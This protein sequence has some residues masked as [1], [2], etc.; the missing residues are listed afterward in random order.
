MPYLQRFW[1]YLKGLSRRTQIIGGLVLIAIVV[2]GVH[3]ATRPAT[4][5]STASD[6]SHVSLASVAELSSGST[7]ISLVGKVSSLNQ[8]TILAQAGG[9]LTSLSVAL[10]SYVGAGGVI[11]QVENSSQSA[12]VLQAQGAYDGA[13]AAQSSVSPVDARTAALNAYRSAYNT[14]DTMLQS[15]VDTFFGDPTPYGPQLLINATMYNFGDLSRERSKI[16]ADMEVYQ[17]SLAGAATADPRKLLDQVT[18]V[19]QEISVF[20]NK[21]ATAANDRNSRATSDQLDALAKAR[22]TTDGVIAALAGA[23]Q[24]YRAGSVG[25]TAGTSASVTSALGG[26]RAAQANLAKTIIRSTISGTIVSLPVHKGDFIS[27][28]DTIAVVSNPQALAVDTYVTPSDAKRFAVGAKAVLNGSVAG[29]IVSIAPAL[30]PTTNKIQVKIGITGDQKELTDGDTVSVAIAQSNSLTPVAP[31]TTGPLSI[32]LAAVKILPDGPIV[33]TVSSS[34]L[35]AQPVTLGA[36]LGEK[37]V[38]QKGVE[39]TTLIVTDA[40]GLSAG[41]TVVVDT[42]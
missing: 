14:L 24:A 23:E 20:E 6:I 39:P 30:D 4:D 19:V 17:K 10:G 5:A 40:R 22:T 12:A 33:F 42:L 32:P 36:I 27:A 3:Y 16:D 21:L 13:V 7:S 2:A 28:G 41:E 25:S 35:V 11:G 34:T 31:T 38:L 9:P 29:V 18:K 15:D 1:A 37:V 8:A 26:L